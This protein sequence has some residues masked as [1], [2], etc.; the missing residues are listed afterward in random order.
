MQRVGTREFKNRMGRY[1][2]AVR[3]GQTL[4]ITARGRVVAHVTP[5]VQDDSSSLSLDER[6]RKLEEQGLIRLG[7]GS[8]LP[9]LKPLKSRGKLASEIIIEER[10]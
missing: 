8:S 5:P 10:R 9:K 7:T 1:M 2:R 3:S 4:M 6:L